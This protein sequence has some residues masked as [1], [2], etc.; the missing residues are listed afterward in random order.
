[1]EAVASVRNV[2]V[3]RLPAF[4]TAVDAET[5]DELYCHRISG[6]P[7]FFHYADVGICVD[8]VAGE[9]RIF[10]RPSD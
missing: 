8:Y 7:V 6:D 1:M 2:R 9:I 3:D 5:L 10:A 4:D